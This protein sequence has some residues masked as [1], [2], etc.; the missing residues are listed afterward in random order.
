ME[1]VELCLYTEMGMSFR[2]MFKPLDKFV[3]FSYLFLILQF[4]EVEGMFFEEKEVHSIETLEVVIGSVY[5]FIIFV[6]H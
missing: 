5:E 4:F 6:L 1:V 3:D 2:V